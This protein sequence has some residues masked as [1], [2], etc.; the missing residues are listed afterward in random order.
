MSRWCGPKTPDHPS[1]GMPCPLCGVAF[2]EGDYTGLVP[3]RPADEEEAAK[4]A[5]GRAHNAE[6]VEVH[7]DCMAATAQAWAEAE[8]E[9]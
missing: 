5:A 7:R 4:A 3:I 1:V 8:R 6:A 2:K 9:Q